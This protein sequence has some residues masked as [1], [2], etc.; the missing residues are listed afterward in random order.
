MSESKSEGQIY[1]YTDEIKAFVMGK[2]TYNAVSKIQ[3]L[4]NEITQWCV[5]NRM[6]INAKK[7][8]AMITRKNAFFGP[9]KQIEIVSNTVD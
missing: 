7:K 2:T 1:H 8:D 5:R 6:T 9:L 4:A 3:C